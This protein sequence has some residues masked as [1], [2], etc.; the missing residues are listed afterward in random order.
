ML[1]DLF[2]ASVTVNVLLCH[3]AE[4][5]KTLILSVPL[6]WMSFCKIDVML[7]LLNV[8]LQNDIMLI[9][10]NVILVSYVWTLSF[11][12]MSFFW[13]SFFLMSFFRMSFFQM[14]F[15]WM[16]FFW[17]P[18]FWMPFFWMSIFLMNSNAWYY[19]ECYFFIHIDHLNAILMSFCRTLFF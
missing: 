1:D 18:F 4:C 12:W 13:M 2:A 8:L 17:M 14:S 11:H 9:L 10:L 19:S 15:F 16:S 5:W 7:M 6:R 3:S